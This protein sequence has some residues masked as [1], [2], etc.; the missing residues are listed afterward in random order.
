MVVNLK[1]ALGSF[2][3]GYFSS[4]RR[5]CL[6]IIMDLCNVTSVHQTRSECMNINEIYNGVNRI[7]ELS[8]GLVWRI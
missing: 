7:L 4:L 3:D 2:D 5:K 6:F 8:K 1:V